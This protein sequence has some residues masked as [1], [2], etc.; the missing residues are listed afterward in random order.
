MMQEDDIMSVLLDRYI[1]TTPDVRGGKP[2]IAG[3]RFTIADLAIKHLDLGQSLEEIARIFH[4]SLAA[5]H[6][7]MAY[8]HD[9]KAE[10]DASIEASEAFAEAFQRENPSLILELP[11]G[12]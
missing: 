3:T 6:A 12:D 4:L 7:G 8:Y 5:V 10:I 2:C 9:H 11:D 1:E